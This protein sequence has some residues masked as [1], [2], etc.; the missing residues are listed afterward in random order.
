MTLKYSRYLYL[1]LFI[2]DIL[3]LNASLIISHTFVHEIYTD[4]KIT[5]L[6]LCI[7][8]VTWVVNSI[9]S[10]SLRTRL[11]AK[12]SDN[13]IC[14]AKA[15]FYHLLCI[16]SIIYFFKINLVSRTELTLGYSL[17]FISVAFLRFIVY[18]RVLYK[19][20]KAHV[21]DR[22]IVI[23]E[24]NVAIRFIDT[25]TADASRDY[26]LMDFISQQQAL[27]MPFWDLSQKIASLRPHRIYMCVVKVDEYLLKQ[28]SAIAENHDIKFRVVTDVVLNSVHAVSLERYG[29]LPVLNITSDHCLSPEKMF[30]KRS[31][32]ILFSGVIMLLGAP[33]F[34]MVA[35]ITKL[36]SKGPV[37]YRQERVG[38][39]GQ[40]FKI[41]KFRSMIV[42]SEVSGPQLTINND[43]RITKWGYFMRK[44]RLDELPQFWNVFKG[45]MSV[46]GPRPERRYFI[47]QIIQ[48]DPTYATLLKLKPGVTSLGQV[49]YGYADSIDKMCERLRYD[50]HYLKNVDFKADL[51]IIYGTVRVMMQGKGK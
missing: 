28:I 24:E 15:L 32:D 49:H 10:Q 4:S 33:T 48:R 21:K 36:S 26:Q 7:V 23:G 45:D 41:I 20:S 38:L 5:L 12:L 25:L 50:L 18:T 42:N 22:M 14:L 40:T 46:V 6:F 43:P 3:A 35:L 16:G 17:F 13:I 29:N 2:A 31:F 11:V 27:N 44:T 39:G 30:L 8:N 19:R 1:L 37:F 47:D 9:Q 51:S 34:A